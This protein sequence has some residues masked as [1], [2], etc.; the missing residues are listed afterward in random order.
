MKFFIL[1]LVWIVT[2]IA[3]SLLGEFTTLEMFLSVVIEFLLLGYMWFYSIFKSTL[4][5]VKGE[6]K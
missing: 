5:Y 3:M 4:K 6:V 2:I 1:L